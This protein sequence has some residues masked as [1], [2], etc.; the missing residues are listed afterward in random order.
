MDMTTADCIW[1][2]GL[3]PPG[4][5]LIHLMDPLKDFLL[6]NFKLPEAYDMAVICLLKMP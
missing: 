6:I 4:P 1:I 2:S 3:A 5:H